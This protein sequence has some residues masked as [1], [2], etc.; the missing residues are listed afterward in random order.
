[1]S[2]VNK[3]QIGGD[4][5]KLQEIQ[6]WDLAHSLDF[7]YF[8]SA[9]TKYIERWRDKNGVVDLKKAHHYLCKERERW[10]QDTSDLVTIEDYLK[11]RPEFDPAQ[12]ELF[13]KLAEYEQICHSIYIIDEG[14]DENNPN[15]EKAGKLL[16][17]VIDLLA[18][19]VVEQ[20]SKS[21]CP[22][23]YHWVGTFWYSKVT[24]FSFERYPARSASDDSGEHSN[25]YTIENSDE[26]LYVGTVK[27]IHQLGYHLVEVLVNK[28]NNQSETVDMQLVIDAFKI[29][30]LNII[31]R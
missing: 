7:S 9:A 12:V 27:Y 24:G 6:H 1:M 10:S 20:E 28:D 11:L 16:D 2:E 3:I 29:K 31:F 4:H 23:P 13:T 25:G 14:E 26:T 15:E 21:N 5:Y 22:G 30:K 18:D 8:V 17:E 19:Y